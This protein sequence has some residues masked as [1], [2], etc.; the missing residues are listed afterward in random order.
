[1]S[2]KAVSVMEQRRELVRL[3]MMEGANR[4]EL[5][6]RFGVSAETGY[7]WIGRASA[8]SD[9]ADRSRKPLRNPLRCSNTV[10]QMVLRVRD[11]HPAWGARKIGNV[12]E[13]QGF[14]VPATSTVHAILVRHERIFPKRGGES[15]RTCALS[16][17]N[18]MSCG[19]WTS[20]VPQHWAMVRDYIL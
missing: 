8:D 6:R 2:W 18:P 15:L 14:E 16:G 12:L 10:E 5:F 1:M 9:F 13:R 17:L 11:Q 7:K 20:R 3:A 19:R 4:R